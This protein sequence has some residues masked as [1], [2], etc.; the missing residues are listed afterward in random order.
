MRDGKGR[1]AQFLC[2]SALN[3]FALIDFLDLLATGA[4]CSFNV[5]FTNL[6]NIFRS[7]FRVMSIRLWTSF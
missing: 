4:C 6:S 2:V 3:A 5:V 7:F 1:A